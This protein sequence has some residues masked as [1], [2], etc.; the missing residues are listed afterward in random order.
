MPSYLHPGVYV[1]EIPS[2]VKPIEGVA[3]SVTACVGPAVKGPVARTTLIQSWDD[4]TAVYGDIASEDDAMGLAVQGFYLN[5]GKTAHI[6]RLAGQDCTPAHAML[7]GEGEAGGSIE[8]E[9]LSL[10]ASSPGAWGNASSYRIVKPD[11]DTPSFDLEIGHVEKGEFHADEIHAGLTLDDQDAGYAPRRVEN[12]SNRVRLVLQDATKPGDAKSQYQQGS[13]TGGP[14]ATAAKAIRKPFE[15]LQTQNPG[16]R[17]TLTLAIDGLT[18]RRIT[19]DPATLA[20][21]ESASNK[22]DGELLAEAIVGAV[23]GLGNDSSYQD[24]HCKYTNERCFVL[25]SG[26]AGPS[27]AVV[28]FDGDK[29]PSDLAHILRLDSAARA[30][31]VGKALDPSKKTHFSSGLGGTKDLVLTLDHQP[32]FT[33]ELDT[34]QLTLVGDHY[35]D[36][37]TVACALRKAVR[38]HAPSIASFAG[39][40]CSYEKP[41]IGETETPHMVLTS[42]SSRSRR[43]SISIEGGSLAPILGLDSGFTLT[44]GRTLEHGTSRVVPRQSLG[45]PPFELGNPLLDGKD[46]PA[47][48]ADYMDFFGRVLRKVRNVSILVLPGEQWAKD[49]SGNAKIGAAL[50]H[51]ESTGSRML[52]VDPPAD[53]EL[54]QA[55]TIQGMALPT[56][57]YG[58]LYYP[59]VAVANPF[60]DRD[61]NPDASPTLRIPP[62]GLVAGMW[63]K[64]DGRRGVWKAPA[65]VETALLGVAGLQYSVEDGEQ[66]Q[67][68][69][70]G[71]NALRVLPG[72]GPVIWGARTLSTKATPEWRYVPVRRTAIFLEQSLYGG[73][74]WAVFEPNDH[75]LWSALRTNIA[76]FM[77]GLHRAG[78]FQ[79]EKASDAYFVRCG[80]GDTMTQGDIDRG[81]VIVIVGFAPLKPAEFVIVRLQQKVGQK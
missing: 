6:A 58:V 57:T 2:G 42:G 11:C 37:E 15:E 54:D 4:Y 71:V 68:N 20:W 65:G 29:G 34:D 70:L 81:Q 14:M 50:A 49:G 35:Q 23:K 79:G 32:T 60:Y 73:I 10:E 75:L 52:I 36:G 66:D 24:F 39:F 27:S 25:S 47:G 64:I 63:S 45:A 38:A 48:V 53:H 30:T 46:D 76:S 16:Q 72:F 40:E 7:M 61:A 55:T 74:Q 31:L 9:V 33:L 17:V 28:V 44:P 59:W 69:P 41:K 12:S 22:G 67:L 78:A 3:T 13:T 80:L 77:D 19:L 51:C 8:P 62:S 26:H 43:S 21:P 56:S 18:A 5:G 1:E